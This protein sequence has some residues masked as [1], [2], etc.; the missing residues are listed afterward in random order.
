MKQLSLAILMYTQD[1]DETYPI[2]A[3]S[4]I[5]DPTALY[6]FAIGGTW[7]RHVQPYCKNTGVFIC[8]SDPGG[9]GFDPAVNALGPVLSYAAN[10]YMHAIPGDPMGAWQIYGV[11]GLG[12]TSF[13][14]WL[15]GSTGVSVASVKSPAST[16]L[17][18]EKDHV[19]PNAS[20]WLG[21]LLDWGAGSLFT[22]Q[23]WYGCSPD[24]IPCNVPGGAGAVAAC[25]GRNVT[26]YNPGAR[27]D[28]NN[29][30]GG[31]MAVHNEVANVAF[32]D[33]HVKAMRPTLTN[34]D[35]TNHPE[36]NMW[37]AL[38]DR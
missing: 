35:P 23:Q 6:S 22:G 33:G 21:N 4:N 29:P 17:I 2:G 8:P 31:V 37:N 30:N 25:E 14:P 12:G 7:Y 16:V 24:R 3:D 26:P 11:I 15:H 32:C 9:N 38:A 27:Y 10:G 5:G 36:K 34:P 18:S 1:Y 20:S 19:W 13:Q 28:P